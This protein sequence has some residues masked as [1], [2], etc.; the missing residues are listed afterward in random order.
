MTHFIP[1][2]RDQAFLLPPDAKDWLPADDVAHFVVAAVDR[3]PLGAFA[4][5]PL[6]GGKAQ[7]HPRLLL[8]LLIYAYANGIFSSRRI[9]RATYRD[10]GVR[11][12]AANLHPD[13][14]TIATFRRANRTAF[15]AAF[16]QVLLLAREAGLLRLGTVSIDGTKLDAN[17]SKI[18]SVR[19][20]RA[21][22]LREKLAADIAA[23]AVQAEA[24][25]AEAQPDPQAL[26]A[27]IARREALKARLDAACARLEEQAR[28]EAEAARPEYEAKQAAY[29]AKKGRRGRPPKPPEDDPPPA[30][31]SNL[32]DP[33]SA[34]M[35]RSDAHEYRQAYNAQAVVCAEGSQL[36]LATGV[37]AT[38][39]DAP[40]FA[41]T[42]LGMEQGIGLP[43]TVLADTGF[44]SAEA[45]AALQAKGIEPL[46]A[47]GR[48]QSHRPYDF[49]PPPEPKTARRI[50]EPWRLAMQAKL[51]SPD[52]RARYAHRKQTV[53][54]VFGIIRSALGFTRFHL[55]GLANVT[56]EWNLIALAYNC[57]RLHRLR[58]AT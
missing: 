28:V 47:I 57:R 5:R 4:V 19:Y 30:R 7:Y 29:D 12:V 48:T 34:L 27:E 1:F 44:A 6:P 13:H 23:L 14:D 53:E 51:E 52:A 2:S 33:D 49:R 17:A 21:K 37:V 58:L 10:L 8:A 11:Y 56:A 31:Q 50:T 20:D 36:I 43:K 55:R 15:E 38:T 18:R 3:V 24:A 32:T 16:L 9:E 41:S 40:S 46:V 26:P 25:D 22:A 42:I 54:P 35:R 39:A 45:V